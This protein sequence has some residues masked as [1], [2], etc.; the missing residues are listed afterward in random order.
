MDTVKSSNEQDINEGKIFA[1]LAYLSI[2]CIIPLLFKKDNDFVLVH[3]KQGLVI[4][5]GQ[6][7]VFILH[8][9]LGPWFLKLGMFILLVFSFIGIISALTGRYIA[10]PVV[11]K[12]ADKITL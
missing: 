1:I 6:V 4:F 5:V 12:I 3:G 9:I 10:L 7:G 11:A 8:I 2:L